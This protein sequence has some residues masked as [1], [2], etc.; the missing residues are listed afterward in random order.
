MD[1]VVGVILAAVVGPMGAYIVAA[2]KM[3]GQIKDS[4]ATELWAES[5]SIREWSTS[6]VKEL[7]DH[8][9]EL[10][11]RLTELEIKNGELASENR[12]L[13]REAV[14]AQ[15]TIQEQ[16]ARIETLITDLDA[17]RQLINRLQWEAEHAPRRRASDP[18]VT[19]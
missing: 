17:A 11:L 2:R 18:D 5:R 3:S 7:D 19:D 14:E 16:R 13:V 4:E 1:P 9:N 6:R 8:V 12:R 10:E 15:V